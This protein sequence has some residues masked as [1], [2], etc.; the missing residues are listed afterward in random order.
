MRGGPAPLAS[1]ET[2]GASLSKRAGTAARCG[3]R[4]P[5]LWVARVGVVP[6]MKDGH[7]SALRSPELR[8][9]SM[10]SLFQDGGLTT[11]AIPL[12]SLAKSGAVQA[13]LTRAP[14]A[15][16]GSSLKRTEPV[17]GGRVGSYL[18]GIQALGKFGDL[19]L[20]GPYGYRRSPRPA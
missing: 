16:D 12:S 10:K 15:S 20:A 11:L 6:N 3:V 19:A 14:K 17:L 4:V 5:V 2:V 8:P 1:L 18:G 13:Q 9:W 7:P